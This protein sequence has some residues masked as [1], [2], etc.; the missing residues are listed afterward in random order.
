MNRYLVLI[1]LVFLLCCKENEILNVDYLKENGYKEITCNTVEKHETKDS[2]FLEISKKL[3]ERI[4][5]LI[6]RCFAED[7]CLLNIQLNSDK[8]VCQRYI[9]S[10]EKYKKDYTRSDFKE[11]VDHRVLYLSVNSEDEKEIIMRAN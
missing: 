2:D 9:L 8:I 5:Y 6:A 7:S 4:T 3:N 11:F 10:K 1:F